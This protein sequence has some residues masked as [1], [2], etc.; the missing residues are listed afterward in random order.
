MHTPAIENI[1][2][3]VLAVDIGTATMRALFYIPGADHEHLPRFVLPSPE[4]AL[5]ARIRQNAARH[6]HIYLHGAA[7][8]RRCVPALEEHLAAGLSVGMHP[9]TAAFFYPDTRALEDTGIVISPAAP[10]LFTSLSAQDVDPDF[11]H[12]LMEDA[13][14]PRPETILT[15]VADDGPLPR[16]ED[17]TG[18]ERVRAAYFRRLF[19][20]SRGEGTVLTRMLYA[21]PPEPFLRLRAIQRITQCPVADGFTAFLLGGM[22]LPTLEKRSL[23][24]GIV[25]LYAGNTRLRAGL[26]FRGRLWGVCERPVVEPASLPRVLKELDDFRLGWLTAE[27]LG[28]PDG[29][30]SMVA[31]LPAEAEG[32]RPLFAG[33]PRA[34]MFTEHGQIRSPY[35][36]AAMHGCWGLLYGY[37]R[38]EYA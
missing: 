3:P 18:E 30:V 22:S 32:F 7:V 4:T 6:R 17:E 24:E 19:A 20:E 23:R 28:A 16:G 33:G 37:S 2:S 35:G 1:S 27:A 21:E 25:L 8:S 38:N 15:A 12:R 9:Q 36:D 10:P 5:I 29:S 34:A 14:L 13:G 31:P 26:L 11:W